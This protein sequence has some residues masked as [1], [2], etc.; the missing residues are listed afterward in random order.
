DKAAAL[1]VKELRVFSDSE[2]LVRQMTG[3]YRVKHP[4]LQA[5]YAEAQGLARRFDGVSFAHVRREQNKRADELCNLVLDAA[6]KKVTPGP[7]A[8]AGPPGVVTDAAVRA[9]AV[10]CLAAAARSWAEKGAMNLPPGQ[11]WDQLWSI[12][13]EG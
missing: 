7:A 5:L 1:G 4:D 9:D 2:L 13:E 3:E 11:V 12:L 6:K 8:A 10:A